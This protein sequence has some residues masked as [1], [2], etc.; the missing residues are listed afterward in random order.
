[1]HLIKETKNTQK[2]NL[3]TIDSTH[4]LSIN[5]HLMVIID[6]YQENQKS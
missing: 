6:N 5:Q 4:F 3:Q 1:M 2:I